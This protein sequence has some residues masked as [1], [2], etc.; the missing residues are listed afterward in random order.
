[1]PCGG[2]DE[3]LSYEL[4][5]ISLPFKKATRILVRSSPCLTYTPIN[6]PHF[7]HSRS[8]S[9]TG[10]MNIPLVFAQI[11]ANPATFKDGRKERRSSQGMVTYA[12]SRL[13]LT[14]LL[15]A[16]FHFHFHFCLPSFQPPWTSTPSSSITHSH[17][18]E[19]HNMWKFH[20]KPSLPLP[21]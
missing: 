20:L 4:S 7:T 5:C 6:P 10:L 12:S 2:G 17:W 8:S 13:F 11:I 1:M 21:K 18:I 15:F 9:S 3:N 16:L 14:C 19:F